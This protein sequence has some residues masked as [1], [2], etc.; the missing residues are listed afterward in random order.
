MI[1]N[2]GY[3]DIGDDTA[4]V[5]DMETAPETIPVHKVFIG[6]DDWEDE[7]LDVYYEGADWYAAQKMFNKLKG[8][9]E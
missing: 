7:E 2:Q 4:V 1:E 6:G 5:W 8:W 9:F 3:Y